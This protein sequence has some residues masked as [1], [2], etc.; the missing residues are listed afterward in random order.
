MGAVDAQFGVRESV[1]ETLF[2]SCSSIVAVAGIG[3]HDVARRNH[4][5]RLE[6]GNVS[7][8][9]LNL[10]QSKKHSQGLEQMILPC[11]V[12]M[13]RRETRAFRCTR[14]SSSMNEIS[15]NTLPTGREPSTVAILP[16]ERVVSKT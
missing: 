1:L 9:K 16:N 8:P 12:A 10:A 2:S 6:D 4:T 5:L 3:R 11:C 7:L 13:F 15:L 14:P